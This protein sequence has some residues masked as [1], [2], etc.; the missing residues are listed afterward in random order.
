MKL[1]NT[2]DDYF[3]RAVKRFDSDISGQRTK[4][5]EMFKELE[6]VGHIGSIKYLGKCYYDGRG[7]E[8]DLDKAREYYLMSIAFGYY[9]ANPGPTS[10]EMLRNIDDEIIGAFEIAEEIY[11]S[12]DRSELYTKSAYVGYVNT[13]VYG[14]EKGLAWQRLGDMYYDGLYVDKKKEWAVYCYR[15]AFTT[16]GMDYY[17]EGSNSCK[18]GK[19]LF[20]GE[21]IDKSIVLAKYFLN[22]AYYSFWDW[23]DDEQALLAESLLSSI[24]TLTEDYLIDGNRLMEEDDV[25]DDAASEWLYERPQY[26]KTTA[27]RM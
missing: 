12:G 17:E 24:G 1:K 27:K 11:K 9:N 13:I 2:Y 20:Y 8:K 22:W 23:E 21:G 10:Y 19:C 7:C 4:A 5:F 26:I 6:K 18:L 15:R 14:R 16:G 25:I 3:L